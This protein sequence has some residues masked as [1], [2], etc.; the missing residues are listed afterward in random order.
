M[1]AAF[2]KQFFR[3]Q[4]EQYAGNSGFQQGIDRC[5]GAAPEQ[6]EHGAEKEQQRVARPAAPGAGPPSWPKERKP[7]EKYSVPDTASMLRPAHS[8][9]ARPDPWPPSHP[10][11]STARWK[12]YGPGKNRPARGWRPRQSVERLPEQKEQKLLSF[13]GLRCVDLNCQRHAVANGR[14]R[15]PGKSPA[16]NRL[17]LY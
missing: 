16:G 15:R 17:R 14:S 7:W 3:Q 6:R 11:A 8:P 9:A 4:E 12:K 2:L 1:P 5:L 13:Q 10:A